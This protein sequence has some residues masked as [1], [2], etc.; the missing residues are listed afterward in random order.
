M[1]RGIITTIIKI[2]KG[3]NGYFC[4]RFEFEVKGLACKVFSN[5]RILN[6]NKWGC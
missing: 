6:R 4:K 5:N 1:G 3:S 2:M